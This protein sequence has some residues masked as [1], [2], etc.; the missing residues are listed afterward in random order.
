MEK[1]LRIPVG[2]VIR[3]VGVHINEQPVRV[4]S[5]TDFERAQ[6]LPSHLGIVPFREE[7][8]RDPGRLRGVRGVSMPTN[9][10]ANVS[11]RCRRAGRDQP[12]AHPRSRERLARAPGA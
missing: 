1:S 11:V 9:A 4:F 6:D 5:G 8:L 12:S 2:V 7:A 3:T 10:L